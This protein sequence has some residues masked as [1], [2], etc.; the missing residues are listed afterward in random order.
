MP[1]PPPGVGKRDYRLRSCL[2]TGIR[3]EIAADGW[4]ARFSE[5]PTRPA[6]RGGGER[7]LGLV[8]PVCQRRCFLLFAGVGLALRSFYDGAAE[9]IASALLDRLDPGYETDPWR[10]SARK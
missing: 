7:P 6:F 5:G 3:R 9:F 2:P 10:D 8:P 1:R 4:P